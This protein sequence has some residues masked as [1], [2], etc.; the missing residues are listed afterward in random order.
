MDWV[1]IKERLPEKAG[2]CLVV[3]K[4]G[5]KDW[6]GIC[7]FRDGSFKSPVTHWM[8]LPVPPPEK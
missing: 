7:D 3:E 1:C 5:V 6:I 8:P 2:R 4:W